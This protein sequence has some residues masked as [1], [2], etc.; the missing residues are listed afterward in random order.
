MK[1]FILSAAAVSALFLFQS[2]DN[3]FD[4]DVTSVA[5]TKG[6]ADFTRYI[7]LGNSLTSGYRDNALYV[8]G[9]NE[10][11]PNMLAQQMKL[12]GGGDFK[13]P[14]MGDNLG[15]IAAVGFSNKLILSVVNGSLSPVPA[16]GTGSTTLANIYSSGPYQNMGVPGA[17]SFHLVAPGYG[18][19]QNLALGAAN[20]YFVRFASSATTSV[21]ADAMAQKP[22]FYSLWIGNNDVLSYATNGGTNAVTANGVTTYVPA[23]YQKGN[24][25][26]RTYKSND[27]SD[28]NVVAGS[29]KAILY[30]MKSVGA[31]GVI[32]NIPDVTTI[33]FFN[34]IPYNTISLTAARAQALNTGLYGPIKQALTALGEGSRINLVAEGNNPV[35]IKDNKLAD[36]T[37]QLTAVLTAAGMA[38]AQAAFL[39]KA[40]GQTRQAKAGEL[41]LL[42]ASSILGKDVE[43]GKDPVETTKF[44][45]GASFPIGDELSLTSDEVA[46]ISAAVTAYNASISGLASTYGL[47]LVNANGKMAE[48]SKVSGIQYNGVKYTAT[49]VTGGAFSLDGVHLTGRGYAVIANEFISA[50]NNQYKSNLPMVNPNSYSGVTF[51]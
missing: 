14:L 29:I 33:P 30:G 51:P 49:F 45:Y 10:S 39:G 15:G 16:S 21:L 24:T 20:P 47:A 2:C 41:I 7:A 5:V 12:A 31:K 8:D 44:I 35:L 17:K 28:P 19:A 40:F 26:P 36:K 4:N 22:T 1:K 27:I 13:Q 46:N 9:Q 38:P 25:D 50:I 48:L 6:E 43:T 18:S 34:R 11:Y 42:K 3:D 37:A 23:T 32:A